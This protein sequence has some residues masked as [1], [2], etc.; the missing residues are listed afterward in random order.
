MVTCLHDLGSMP[1]VFGE[2][3]GAV[4]VTPLTVTSSEVSMST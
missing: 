3:A 1:S 2:L 4:M